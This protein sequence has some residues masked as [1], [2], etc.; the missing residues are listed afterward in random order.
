MGGFEGHPTTTLT[1][2]TPKAPKGFEGLSIYTRYARTRVRSISR[3]SFDTLRM[4]GR[5]PFYSDI[6][7]SLLAGVVARLGK[8]P[9]CQGFGEALLAAGFQVHVLHQIFQDANRSLVLLKANCPSSWVQSS[10]HCFTMS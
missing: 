4:G 1:N 10:N 6:A 3:E 8:A 9:V 2:P 5:L 7:E